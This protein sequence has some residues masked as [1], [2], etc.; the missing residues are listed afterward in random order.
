[1]IFVVDSSD[2]D[3]INNARKELDR[4][5]Q[6]DDM[7]NNIPLLVFANKQDLPNVMTVSEITEKLKLNEMRNRS[8][9]NPVMQPQEME[10][11]MVWML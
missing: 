4:L 8:W 2:R 9:Y 6:E 5:L 3:R 1:M 7:P 11:M 10:Y